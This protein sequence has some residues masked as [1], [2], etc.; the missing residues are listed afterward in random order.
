MPKGRRYIGIFAVVFSSE[1]NAG[2]YRMLK[3]ILD[4][5]VFDPQT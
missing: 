5:N 4:A 2:F 1:K 3:D